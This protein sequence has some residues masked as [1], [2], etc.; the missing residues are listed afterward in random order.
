MADGCCR[1]GS[2]N[3][4]QELYNPTQVGGWHADVAALSMSLSGPSYVAVCAVPPCSTC[5]RRDSGR[6]FVETSL[7]PGQAHFFEH[8]PVQI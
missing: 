2:R 4:L 7:C 3:A 6:C 5:R 8:F 1:K